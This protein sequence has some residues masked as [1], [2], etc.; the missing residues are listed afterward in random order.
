[1]QLVQD[2]GIKTYQQSKYGKGAY[3]LDA[4][5]SVYGAT[6]KHRTYSIGQNELG[7][8]WTLEF[9]V[10]LQRVAKNTSYKIM[11]LKPVAGTV[12]EISVLVYNNQLAVTLNGTDFCTVDDAVGAKWTHMAFTHDPDS[13]IAFFCDGVRIETMSVYNLYRN[14][15]TYY[16]D[17]IASTGCVCIFDAINF[18]TTVKYSESTYTVPG[19]APD[20]LPEYTPS[21][22]TPTDNLHEHTITFTSTFECETTDGQALPFTTTTTDSMLFNDNLPELVLTGGDA[23]QPYELYGYKLNGVHVV[24]S[25]PITENI[26]LTANWLKSAITFTL[27]PSENDATVKLIADDATQ[28]GNSIVVKPYQTVR[29]V[30]KKKNFA[31]VRGVYTMDEDDATLNVTMEP[32]TERWYSNF[33][34]NCY[35]TIP[36]ATIGTADAWEQVWH[37][38]TGNKVNACHYLAS[39]DNGIYA[40]FGIS[41]LYW[42]FF[43]SSDNSSWNI[44]GSNG[45][46]NVQVERNTNYWVK[47]EFTGEQYVMS[48]A[49]EDEHDVDNWKVVG[50]LA[51]TTKV[52]P[53]TT[54]RVG[55]TYDR[56]WTWFS[57]IDIGNSY[58]KVNHKDGD[59]DNW[60]YDY[61]GLTAESGTD[62]TVVGDVLL[63]G[64]ELSDLVSENL[65]GENATSLAARNVYVYTTSNMNEYYTVQN[66]TYNHTGS[67]STSEY[68]RG[69][70]SGYWTGAVYSGNTWKTMD[71]Y[72]IGQWYEDFSCS[73]RRA[74]GWNIW[75]SN[76][77]I[78]PQVS[79]WKSK[80]TLLDSRSGQFNHNN[81]VYGDQGRELSYVIA[82]D[83]TG[84]AFRS[85]AVE[86]TQ[87]DSGGGYTTMYRFK[88]YGQ[89]VED[90]RALST[91]T[92]NCDK[93]DAVISL[94]CPNAVQSGNSITGRD[95]ET[96]T[97]NISKAGYYTVS[98]THVLD[99]N[100]T[101][102]VE[103][104]P[105]VPPYSYGTD[106]YPLVDCYLRGEFGGSEWPAL[107]DFQF[108][109]DATN[110]LY[111]LRKDDSLYTQWKIASTD[112]STLDFGV[113]NSGDYIPMDNDY[114]M[115]RAG[116]NCSEGA[117]RQFSTITFNPSNGVVHIYP[118]GIVREDDYT[119]TLTVDQ[120]DA[121]ITLVSPGFTQVGNSITVKPCATITYT[122]AKEGYKT[123]RG[124]YLMGETNK[125]MSVTMEPGV[126]EQVYSGF[127]TD[128]YISVNASVPTDYSDV[129]FVSYVRTGTTAPMRAAVFGGY[130]P[131][132][133]RYYYIGTRN[134]TW[135]FRCNTSYHS[136]TDAFT[137]DAWHWIR[138][139]GTSGNYNL[140]I[141][142]D[143]SRM[144][145]LTT[146]PPLGSWTLVASCT[147]AASTMSGCPLLIGAGMYTTADRKVGW[148]G[149]I[150]IVNTKVT[151]DGTTLYDGTTAKENVDYV[152][153]GT[154]VDE[155]NV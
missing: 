80:C 33:D 24:D 9:W 21:P 84:V 81:Y 19:K 91:F 66:Y 64:T 142:P 14:V 41:G 45:I 73:E 71:Y 44:T 127:S 32:S 75:V 30:V 154:L 49:T 1:M 40:D 3:K 109:Y 16:L 147:H 22:D 145:S 57:Y 120:V 86:V 137:R 27:V 5:N 100:Y 102:N 60:T 85:L 82:D 90:P 10:N 117:A 104:V 47:L 136:S 17:F 132:T 129:D 88:A 153:V 105:Y 37:V 50:T 141:L 46:G 110:G 18:E 135:S 67:W 35:I 140:Y 2:T 39:G 122:V 97:Y 116:Y 149:A 118:Y 133:N 152:I 108:R 114:G 113:A 126:D 4:Y 42:K 107:P 134:S 111:F 99:G 56:Y 138:L 124:T 143:A 123:I 148:T 20:D 55:T 151:V 146:L 89:E 43:L 54:Y 106:T 96:V 93:N 76:D 65:G 101:L 29:Y 103:M 139:V 115:T 7:Q 59:N 77:V 131:D 25:T 87:N 74:R 94:S 51:S 23:E 28:S 144:Y 8:T 36:N 31:T 11:N 112:W 119:F 130:S 68:D 34:P 48:V 150:D 121:T 98:G 95:T 83:K 155:T 125:T 26:T 38:R 58:I 72:S 15:G 52:Y 78:N 79:N 70:G 62:F 53:I 92:V 12:P 128:N 61:N 6:E 69:Q 63:L 13:G